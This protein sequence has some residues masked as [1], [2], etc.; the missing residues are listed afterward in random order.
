LNCW[1][2]VAAP[3]FHV[4]ALVELALMNVD[5][6]WPPTGVITQIGAVTKAAPNVMVQDVGGPDPTVTR[7]AVSDAVPAKAGPVPHEDRVGVDAAPLKI[8]PSTRR[9]LLKAA[10]LVLIK[11]SPFVLSLAKPRIG[12]ALVPLPRR[13]NHLDDVQTPGVLYESKNAV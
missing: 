12:S 4:I 6:C 7:P 3:Q 1:P 11:Y 5:G 13:W 2:A 9:F 10:L 8:W